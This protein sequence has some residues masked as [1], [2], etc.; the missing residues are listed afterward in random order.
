MNFVTWILVGTMAGATV[1][2]ALPAQAQTRAAALSPITRTYPVPSPDNRTVIYSSPDSAGKLK[3][4]AIDLASKQ[5]SQL[6]DGASEDSAAVYS[7]DGKLIAFQREGADGSRDIWVMGADG[8]GQRKVTDTPGVS[9]QHPAFTPDG[10]SVLFD[11]NIHADRT[12]PENEQNYEIYIA[13]LAGGSIRRLTNR[14][15]WDMYPAVSPDGRLVMWHGNDGGIGPQANFDLYLQGLDGSGQR[16]LAPSPNYESTPAWHPSGQ[17]VVFVSDRD[18]RVK[19]RTDLFVVDIDGRNLRRVT[20]GGGSDLAYIR[21]RFA[22]D[23]KTIL[24]NRNLAGMIDIARVPLP[25]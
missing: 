5:V 8:S 11:A 21:P 24:V 18:A 23:G 20:D 16:T 22:P 25:D 19:R 4:F 15:G 6:T 3:I 17:K 2:V 9:E 12:K 14:D 10:R 1:A 13:G 7:A